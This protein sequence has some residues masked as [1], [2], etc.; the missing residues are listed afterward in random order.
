M[1]DALFSIFAI[2]YLT[3]RLYL[4]VILGWFASLLS[5]VRD[6]FMLGLL[7]FTYFYLFFVFHYYLVR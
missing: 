4:C 5:C 2:N 7:E 1:H 6:L 3:S